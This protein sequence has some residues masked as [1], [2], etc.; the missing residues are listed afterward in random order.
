MRASSSGTA[1]AAAIAAAYF[2]A[3][4]PVFATAALVAVFI[5]ADIMRLLRVRRLAMKRPHRFGKRRMESVRSMMEQGS[6]Q[7]V[8][9]LSSCTASKFLIASSSAVSKGARRR[10]SSTELCTPRFRQHCRK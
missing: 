5:D 4:S 6:S 2:F 9:M 7:L 8:K 10:K 1:A 3:A